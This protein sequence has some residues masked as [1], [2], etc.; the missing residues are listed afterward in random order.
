MSMTDLNTTET[1]KKLSAPP[2]LAK[3]KAALTK[4]GNSW[5]VEWEPKEFEN[6]DGG[7][8]EEAMQDICTVLNAAPALID[9]LERLAQDNRDKDAV[10]MSQEGQIERLRGEVAKAKTLG[11][12]EWHEAQ[13]QKERDL[14]GF[15][16]LPARKHL[17]IAAELRK[18]LA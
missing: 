9:E 3:L 1:A 18:E 13:A 17:E 15:Y 11:A 5:D 14:D 7:F 16:S 12:A 4:P 6:A 2:D 8:L 10:I